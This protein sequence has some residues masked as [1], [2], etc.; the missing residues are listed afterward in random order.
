VLGGRIEAPTPA[1][2]VA[3]AVPKG[4]NTGT[5]LRLKGRGV[6]RPDGSRGDAYATLRVVLPDRPDPEL[7][8]FA[9]RWAAGKSH[10]PRAG[11]E[12]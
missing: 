5:V 7:E 11:M 1:G 10:D 2:P 6:P 3:V 4:A 9:A 12:G 8:A